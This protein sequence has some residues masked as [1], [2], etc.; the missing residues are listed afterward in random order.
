MRVE[1]EELSFKTEGP[2]GTLSLTFT[3]ANVEQVK[4]VRVDVLEEND[5]F[6]LLQTLNYTIEEELYKGGSVCLSGLTPGRQ[7]VVCVRVVYSNMEEDFAC[8]RLTEKEEFVGSTQGSCKLPT[9]QKVHSVDSSDDGSDGSS[10]ECPAHF[11]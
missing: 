3:I 6:E 1:L 5:D 9:S 2:E 7:Y 10:G 4:S 11:L 8:S